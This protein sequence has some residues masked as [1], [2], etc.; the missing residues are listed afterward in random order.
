MHPPL[1]NDQSQNHLFKLLHRG[2][3]GVHAS[4][5]GDKGVAECPFSFYR[6]WVENPLLAQA[7]V[8]TYSMNLYMHISICIYIAISIYLC[9]YIYILRLLLP[10]G[11]GKSAACT[12]A[13]VYLEYESIYTSI[14]LFT[15][16]HI[17][18][19]IYLSIYVY[20]YILSFSF[21]RTWVENLLLAQAQVCTYSMN[22]YIYTYPYIFLYLS[23]YLSIY[24]YTYLLYIRKH[25]YIHI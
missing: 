20:T 7:Q 13:G 6:T 5:D 24:V 23:I 3:T 18:I 19:S 17:S 10:H 1:Q 22:L 21:Y 16:L 8:C 4:G 14:Y 25:I 11:G 15:Y 9:L 2:Y 12:G